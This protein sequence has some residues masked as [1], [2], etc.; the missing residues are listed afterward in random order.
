MARNDTPELES[1]TDHR[2][3]GTTPR[4]NTV[5]PTLRRRSVLQ[6]LGTGVAF[7]LFGVGSTSGAPASFGDGVNLQP[8]YFCDGDQN[9][10]WG[11][12][13][14]YPDIQT[15]RIEIEPFSFNEI[16]TTRDDAKR[17]IDEAASHG[18]DVIASYHHYPD[19]GSADSQALQSAADWWVEQYDYLTQDSSITINMM[20]EWGDHTVT[21]GQYASAYNDAISTVRDGT[22][23]TGPIVCDAPGWGQETHRLADAVS[24]IDDDD[25]ILSVHVYPSGWNQE[26]NEALQPAHLD[27]VDETGYPCMIGEFGNWAA[28]PSGADWSAIVDH[29]KSLGWPVIGWA[30]NGD[31]SDDPMNMSSP[32]WGN[33]CGATSYSASSYFNV[34]YDKLGSGGSGDDTTAP[35]SP[36]NLSVT[37]TTNSSVSLGWDGATDTGGSGLSQYVI[38][39][40]GSRDHTVSAG[41]T[42]T[43]VSGLSAGTSYEI[44]VRAVDGAGNESTAATVTA[45]TAENGDS[46]ELLAEIA[47][48]TTTAA[49]DERITF[50][51]EDTSGSGQWITALDWAFGDGT[52][53]TG[54]WNEHAYDAAGT[55]TVAL[56]A[57][58]NED[59]TTTHEVTI[60][61]S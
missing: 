29:A 16:A 4:R 26:A 10:G 2:S 27:I 6:A 55:Y 22:D 23:Y 60:T 17:W 59:D 35:S 31:G 30:W 61:V 54:W 28:N 52:T 8:S 42:R 56:T 43:T 14:Q 49:V 33:D 13:N 32:Y 40:D 3:D 24:Q 5:S 19:N 48:S 37:G 12:M 58:D 38:T 41:T 1:N 51:V 47:S 18:Y 36:S 34:V 50:Q 44:G 46:A 9:L 39:V 15:V 20:N 45:T 11:L 21:A 7:G 25:L 57:T 53:A